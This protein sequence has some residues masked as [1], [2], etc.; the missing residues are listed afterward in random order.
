[1]DLE[2][3]KT[4]KPSTV[5]FC[6]EESNQFFLANTRTGMFFPNYAIEIAK[7][8]VADVIELDKKV[9]ETHS[10][11]G[12]KHFIKLRKIYVDDKKRKPHYPC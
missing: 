12:P 5:I 7:N 3:T 2:L 6:N 8:I 4:A 1:M 9:Q 11:F 10:N